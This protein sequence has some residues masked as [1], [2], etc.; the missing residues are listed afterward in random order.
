MTS[1]TNNR[2][3]LGQPRPN[4]IAPQ[5][6]IPRMGTRGTSGVLNP[7]FTSGSVLRMMMT[8]A[9]T[10]INANNVPMLVMSPTISPGTNAENTPTKRNKSMFD[11]YGVRNFGWMSENIFGS[12]PS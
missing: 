11:L 4:I 5:T 7:R 10:R 2:D 6:R 3:Q 8:P 9:H 12:S 1:Q